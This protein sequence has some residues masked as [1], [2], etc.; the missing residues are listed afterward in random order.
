MSQ[1][2]SGFRIEVFRPGVFK[3]MAGDAI[4][5]S[6]EDLAAIAD[7]YDPDESPAPIVVGH[8]S[9]DAPA[10]GWVSGF[11]YD[12]DAERLYADI[13]ELDEQFEG[14][15]RAGRYK[16]VSMAFHTPDAAN[17]PASGS[18]YPKHV[19][20]LGAAAPAVSGLKPVAFAEAGEGEEVI[21]EAAFGEPGF[22]ET[23]SLFR[24]MREFFIEKFGK[25]AADDVLPS[26]RI[27][28]LGERELSTNEP[29]P[30]FAAPQG[31]QAQETPSM[32]PEEI[33]A[34][35]QRLEAQ[36][37]EQDARQAELDKAA[38][39][40]RETDNA[41]FA[42]SM[43]SEGKLLP[44]QKDSCVTFLNALPVDQS[45]SFAEGEEAPMAEAFKAFIKAQPVAV[46]FGEQQMGDDPGDVADDPEQ[47]AQFAQAYQAEKAAAG[48]DIS[49]TEAVAHVSKKGG[50][51]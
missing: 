39:A 46:E 13:D 28:W 37:V 34:E 40:Q 31:T 12:A 24:M 45:V 15:V 38:K 6:S 16:K 44:A 22:E 48:I 43:I 7:G 3:P 2:K 25:D 35:K 5:Y 41:A 50:D 17:N 20:F 42:E 32:T 23:A 19:G 11:E 51:K 29:E 8:P 49:I 47:L 14:M 33:E 4:S 26:Y 18:W 27:E 30:V 36:K 9:V 21:F 1:P 10:Y